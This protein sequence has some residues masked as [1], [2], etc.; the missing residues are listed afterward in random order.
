MANTITST[1][2]TVNTTVNQAPQPLQLQQSGAVV[3]AGGTTL[4]QGTYQYCGSVADAQAVAQPNLP[5][6]SLSWASGTV[7]ATTSGPLGMT[8]GETFKVII[9]GAVPAGYNG[10]FNA[11]ATGASTFTYALATNPGTETAPGYYSP[12][13]AAFVQDAVATHF[14]QGANVGIYIVEIGAQASDAAA[15]TALQNWIALNSDPQL[16]YAYLVPGAWDASS[17]AELSSLANNFSSANGQ[18]YFFVTTTQA[19]LTDY[20]GNKAVFAVVPSPSAPASEEQAA[21]FMYQWL[22]NRPGAANPLAP[23]AYR[24]LFGVTPWAWRG[25]T[26]QRNAVLSAFGNIVLQGAEGGLSNSCIFKGMLMDGSQA[27]FWYGVDWMRTQV[28]QALAAAIINGS[29]QN[30][31][32]LYDQNGINSLQAV[33]QQ[34]G[35]SAVAFGC[36][37]AVTVSAIPFAPYVAANPNDYA[38]GIYNG[39]SATMTGQNG[40]LTITFNLDATQ[41]AS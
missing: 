29:N 10:T 6:D 24:F 3:S 34:V 13:G 19:N 30:P 33:A 41:F 17:A 28:K 20:A 23:M 26:V 7:T 21:A 31:P 15:I 11:T 1:I 37:S 39:L 5:L 27:A 16:F 9:T 4:S 14:A 8:T 18:T 36:A 38:A 40:F 32:L 2:V 22:V 25:T 35:D 12:P